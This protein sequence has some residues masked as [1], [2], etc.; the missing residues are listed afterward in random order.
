MGGNAIKNTQR[1]SAEEYH[2]RADILKRTLDDII[3]GLPVRVKYSVVPSYANKPD[4]GDMDV[5]WMQDWANDID[6]SRLTSPF[7]TET[8]RNGN[9]VSIN[10]DGM[11]LDFI[12]MSEHEYD[13]ALKYY[14]FNDLG[15]LIGRIA[16]TLGFKFGH[17]GLYT[18]A[19]YNNHVVND[20][21]V[22]SDWDEALTMLGF[23]PV[24]WHQGFNELSDIFDYVIG[25]RWFRKEAFLMENRNHDARQRDRKRK[26]YMAFLERVSQF[27]DANNAEWNRHFA[28]QTRDYRRAWILTNHGYVSLVGQ[29]ACEIARTRMKIEARE[30]LPTKQIMAATGLIGKEL[31]QFFEC[32]KI[33]LSSEFRMSYEQIVDLNHPDYVLLL[34][35]VLWK[36]EIYAPDIDHLDSRIENQRQLWL[37]KITL[38]DSER[39]KQHI[40]A[41]ER[42]DGHC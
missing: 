12:K 11:Q 19:E 18:R 34:M 21:C 41:G 20:H 23:D 24:R 2:R 38:E 4:F 14:S 31:G 27:P 10:W 7:G 5:I 39:Y 6:V 33:M 25:S 15:N 42:K 9:V 37:S 28:I 1:V 35:L 13:F 17:D 29:I 16:R 3:A 26:V 22:T 8:V 30:K 32:V 36:K 40:Q